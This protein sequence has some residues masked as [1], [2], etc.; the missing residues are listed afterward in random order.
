MTWPPDYTDT[1]I[2]RYERIEAIRDDPSLIVGAEEYYKTRSIE[3][4]QDWC[5]TYDPR[6][7]SKN[8]PTIM[9]FILFYR[10]IF[11]LIRLLLM[12]YLSALI[13]D[14]SLWRLDTLKEK[15]L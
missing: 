13:F 11:L 7:A 1:F 3:F 9:P 8:I 15:P 6:N 4:I 5:I 14:N 10:Q 12:Q 2:K